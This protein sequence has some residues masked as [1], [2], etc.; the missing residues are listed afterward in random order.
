MARYIRNVSGYNQ[1][2]A[3]RWRVDVSQT[4]SEGDIV[5]IDATSRWI[6]AAAAAST[7]LVGIACQSIT[8]GASVTADDAIDVIPLTGIVVRM[9]YTGSSKTSLADTD[10]VT[11]LFDIDNGTTIDLDDTTGGMCSVVAY[12]NDNDTADVIFAAANIAIIG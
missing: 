11:T 9:D 7:T 4:I 6:E 8:T 5:Q 3:K 1:P 12:D 10:L 2:I